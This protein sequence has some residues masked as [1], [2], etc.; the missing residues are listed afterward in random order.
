MNN[1]SNIGIDNYTMTLWNMLDVDELYS[2]ED[3]LKLIYRIDLLRKQGIETDEM[4]EKELYEE[5]DKIL[6]N[7][8]KISD[9]FVEKEKE[10]IGNKTKI[11][12]GI[13]DSI[14]GIDNRKQIYENR[15]QRFFTMQNCVFIVNLFISH[16]IE[17][18]K[19]IRKNQ[20]TRVYGFCI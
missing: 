18:C 1:E 12:S 13:L 16:N 8:V 5:V 20:Y 11:I 9:N 7:D 14:V 3:I 6:I 4:N 10:W 19:R 15:C 2:I 17:D